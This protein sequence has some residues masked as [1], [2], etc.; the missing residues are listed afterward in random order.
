MLRRFPV[1]QLKRCSLNHIR[2]A[3]SLSLVEYSDDQISIMLNHHLLHFKT[4]FLRDACQDPS[5]VDPY[6][7]QKLFSTTEA[8]TGL[9]VEAPP[10]VIED[11]VTK[12]LKLCVD[13]NTNGV[14]KS[15]EYPISLLEKY[16]TK[17]SRRAGKFF[18]KE[19][20]LWDRQEIESNL[21]QLEVDYADFISN[22]DA[23]SKTLHNLNKYG[24]TFVNNIPEPQLESMNE[25]NAYEWPVAKLASRFGYIKKTFYGTLFD[26]KNENTDAKNIANTN[27]YLPLHMDLLYYESPPGLQ[28]LHFIKNSTIGGES[29]FCDSYLAAQRVKELDPEAYKA[30]TEIPIT[31]HYDNNNEYYYYRRP[32]IIE[33]PD[34]AAVTKDFP[35][36]DVVNYA[37]PFQGP[38]EVGISTREDSSVEEAKQ[39][40]NFDDFLRGLEIFEKTIN[41]PENHFEI[42][43]KEGSCV[44]FENRRALHSRKSFSDENGGD[45][46]LMGTYVDGDS[47][48][49]KLR[50]SKRND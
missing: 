23:L 38:L 36:I 31:F 27:V 3:S 33:D 12:E 25:D 41:E 42:K 21:S 32:L 18:D 26:V 10:K 44:I 17:A 29:V 1:N 20:K 22:Q 30:L 49:S 8:V 5:S 6:N 46:W 11:S 13:W 7:K 15:S 50:V 40:H 24:L 43:M 35:P 28:L 48:R 19:R 34:I 39:Y 9:K 47:F 4:A 2:L 45:R 14:T 16:S 37:P